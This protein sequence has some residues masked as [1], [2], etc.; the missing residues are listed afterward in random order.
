M[1]VIEGLLVLG[2]LFIA[3]T[4]FVALEWVRRPPRARRRVRAEREGRGPQEPVGSPRRHD[5]P[6]PFVPEARSPGLEETRGPHPTRRRFFHWLIGVG[7]AGAFAAMISAA[8]SLK[9]LVVR[10]SSQLIGP[11]DLLQFATGPRKGQVITRDALNVGEAALALPKDK[12]SV[13]DNTLLVIHL[14]PDQ[15]SPPTERE[16]TARGYVA[17]SAICTHLGCTVM[18]QLRSEGI[19]CPCHAGVYDPRRGAIVVSGPPPRPLPQLPVRFNDRGELE[20]AS[21]FPES[22]GEIGA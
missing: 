11:G 5:E 18:E 8:N 17:Y 14:E 15:L 16:W 9:P 19:F 13:E 1:S 6:G 2:I 7:A 21:G 10:E 4:G 20:A 12:E 3:L 22:E